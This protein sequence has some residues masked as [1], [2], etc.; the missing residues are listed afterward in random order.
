MG[1]IGLP[2]LIVVLVILLFLFGAS[3][4]PGIA[5]SIGQ[6]IKEFKKGIS[7]KAQDKKEEPKA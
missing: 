2:E 1:R 6:S 4:L 7:D 3:K 5:K